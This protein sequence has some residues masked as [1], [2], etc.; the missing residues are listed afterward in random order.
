MYETNG[1]ELEYAH[2]FTAVNENGKN[3]PVHNAELGSWETQRFWSKLL[4]AR[5]RSDSLYEVWPFNSEHGTWLF[6]IKAMSTLIP[7]TSQNVVSVGM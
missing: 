7:W 4:S 6:S 3:M 2:N 5:V 1:F